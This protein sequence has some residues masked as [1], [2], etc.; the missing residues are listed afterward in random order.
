M[1]DNRNPVAQTIGD[2]IFGE[3]DD[4]NIFVPPPV[5]SDHSSSAAVADEGLPKLGEEIEKPEIN[6]D[7]SAADQPFLGI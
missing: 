7:A 3:E 5:K 1:A 2:S 6:G 4:E